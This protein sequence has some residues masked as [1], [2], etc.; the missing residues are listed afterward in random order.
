VT[1][2]RVLGGDRAAVNLGAKIA[3]TA[4]YRKFKAND[5]AS[6]NW[7]RVVYASVKSE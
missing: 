6:T 7:M 5:Q 1:G 4:L 3:D 2:F